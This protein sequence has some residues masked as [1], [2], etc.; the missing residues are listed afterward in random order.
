[1]ELLTGS[2]PPFNSIQGQP[3]QCYKDLDTGD[4]YKCYQVIDC[5]TPHFDQAAEYR[6]K[7]YIIDYERADLI[8]TDETKCSFIK[9]K[10]SIQVPTKILRKHRIM[11]PHKIKLL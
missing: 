3:D 1:M 4:I 10:D 7:L 5:Q 8:E 2:G 11:L 6:W 9:N